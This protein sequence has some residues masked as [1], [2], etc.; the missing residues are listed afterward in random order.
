MIII[1]YTKMI[2]LCVVQS[3][4]F[5]TAVCA[6]LVNLPKHGSIDGLCFIWACFYVYSYVQKN[7]K[8]LIFSIN[9]SLVIT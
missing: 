2:K 5:S 9:T 6:R 4:M 3:M 8:R 7:Q 1:Y